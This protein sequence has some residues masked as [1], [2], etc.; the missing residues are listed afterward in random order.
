F[1]IANLHT[2]FGD[3]KFANDGR[4]DSARIAAPSADL[5]HS[6]LSTRISSRRA[7]APIRLGYAAFD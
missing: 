5:R 7:S 4:L 1:A 3:R 2:N 6:A